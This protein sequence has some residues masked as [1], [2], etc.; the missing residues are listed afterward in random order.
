VNK[1]SNDYY[2]G[3]VRKILSKV[4]EG[5]KENLSDKAIS[6]NVKRIIDQEAARNANQ[7]DYTE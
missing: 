2:V 3:L 1:K 7:Q 4:N 6:Q 5:I